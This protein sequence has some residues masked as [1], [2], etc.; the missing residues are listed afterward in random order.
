MISES[1]KQALARLPVQTRLELLEAISES[2]TSESLPV[3]DEH[4]RLLD[5]R[6]KEH[7]ASPEDGDDLDTVLAR[8]EA[9]DR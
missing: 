8:L 5:A 4:K 9:A 7:Q 2:L 3:P 6:L 1:Q